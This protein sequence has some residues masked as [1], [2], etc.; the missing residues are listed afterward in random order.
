M[1]TML[2]ENPGVLSRDLERR[3]RNAAATKNCDVTLVENVSAQAWGSDFMRWS[4]I[5]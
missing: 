1:F 4:E 2:G 5:D 3:G